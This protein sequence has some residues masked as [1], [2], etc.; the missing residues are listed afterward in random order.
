MICAKLTELNYNEILK[1]LGF[2]GQEISKELE[3]QIRHCME[4]TKKC[5]V[6]RLVYA[7]VP[8]LKRDGKMQAGG[9]CLEGNDI[10]E[11]LK[12]C[13]LAVLLAATAGSEISSR[14]AQI[15]VRDKGSALIMDACASAAVENICNNFE[16]ELKDELKADNLYLTDRFSPGYGDLPL[17][18]QKDFCAGLNTQRRIGLTVT[19]NFLM[20]PQKSVTAI[21]GI[22]G[23]PQPK[24]KSGCENCNMFERCAFRKEGTTCSGG[25]I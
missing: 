3:D 13:N 17:S 10:E 15:Q 23:K 24:R 4:E 12:E 21:M 18:L 20:I 11:L 2:R 5:C 1:Y 6:P 19:D 25:N 22:S 16:A 7:I 14:I 9:L 8:L